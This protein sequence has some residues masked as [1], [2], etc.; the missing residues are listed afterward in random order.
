LGIIIFEMIS[1]INPFKIKG[2]SAFA[3]MKMITDPNSKIPYFPI[4]SDK[5]KKLL[6]ALLIKNP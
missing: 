4:F 5:A 6:K 1:G 3:K 2:L